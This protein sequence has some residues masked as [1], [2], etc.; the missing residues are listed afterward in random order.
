MGSITVT[1]AGSVEERVVLVHVGQRTVLVLGTA[2]TDAAVNAAVN[3]LEAFVEDGALREDWA[4]LVVDVRHADV[5][6]ALDFREV[7]R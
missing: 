5:R 7:R 1:S 3:V 6:P 2:G 4:C